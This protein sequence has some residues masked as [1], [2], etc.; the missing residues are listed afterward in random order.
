MSLPFQSR[1]GLENLGSRKAREYEVYVEECKEWKEEYQEELR[2]R[3]M[4]IEELDRKL[5]LRETLEDGLVKLQKHL[6]NKGRFYN[7][8]YRNK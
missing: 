6:E 3:K 8:I 5:E 7:F 4:F 2:R 1:P